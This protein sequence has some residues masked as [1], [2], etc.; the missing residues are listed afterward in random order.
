[1][2]KPI[3]TFTIILI[4]W[5]G[6]TGPASADS[7]ID[8]IFTNQRIHVAR[9]KSVDVVYTEQFRPGKQVLES[10]KVANFH[11]PHNMVLR[12]HK[13][14]EKFRIE[15]ALE[16]SDVWPNQIRMITA[17]DLNKVQR[18][19]KDSLHLRVQSEPIIP[20][21]E[22][23]LPL[24]R[25]YRY[26]FLGRKDFS[27]TML[28]T[29]S[30]WNELKNRVTKIETSRIEEQECVLVEFDYTDKGRICR[31]YF[32]KELLH[33]PIRTEVLNTATNKLTVK[34]IVTDV[35]KR[36]TDQ[37][38]V[39]IPVVITESQWHQDSGHPTFTLRESID[40]SRLFLNEDI[41]DEVFTIPIHM[42]RSYEDVD[43]A[44][45]YFSVDE[46]RNVGLEE[47][48]SLQQ[49]ADELRITD[50]SVDNTPNEYD[51]GG[52]E[53]GEFVTGNNYEVKYKFKMGSRIS[54]ITGLFIV[55]IVVV[56]VVFLVRRRFSVTP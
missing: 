46:V 8:E 35:E 50:K 23:N 42:A 2:N 10:N 49:S 56:L 47:L 17:F 3:A 44:R 13:K 32:A 38:R 9:L 25:P 26:I 18:L 12:F 40:R 15:T 33:Y 41:P 34:L 19:E 48:L 16:G 36:T 52:I 31:T 54:F 39:V 37:G 5:S 27:F 4:A 24:T 29:K 7:L 43:D 6:C 21:R 55:V 28:Q 51:A 45:A 20:S 22:T 53:D 30:V 11:K 14:G 1:M